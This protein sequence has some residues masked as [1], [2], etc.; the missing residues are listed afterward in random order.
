M[1]YAVIIDETN[2]DSFLPQDGKEMTELAD[3]WIGAV[4]DETDT[5]C[6]ILG[7]DYI[8]EEDGSPAFMI[9]VFSVS[10]QYEMK[11]VGDVLFRDLF[12][13]AFALHCF[14]VFA[15]EFIGEGEDE[16]KTF[17]LEN[18]F[19]E[20]DKKMPLYELSISDIKVRRPESELGCLLLSDLSEQQ[21]EVFAEE[22]EDYSFPL[23]DRSRYDRNL[24]V[25]LVDD[26][27]VIQGGMLFSMRDDTVFVEGLAP[28]GSDEELL[29]NDLVFWGSEGVKKRFGADA[30]I[31]LYLPGDGRYRTM[32]LNL[33]GHKAVK[34]G[35]LVNFTFE[36]P[37]SG[38]IV[39]EDPE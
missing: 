21:W 38:G 19:F 14:A 32:L 10:E 4:D 5:A 22:T 36:V 2:R 29:I 17:L 1:Y 39:Y 28:Y 3:L 9:R 13:N 16:L 18:G 8:T 7:A 25:F 24:S 30:R 11:S 35:E 33:T 26:D 37:V 31:K 20:E 23:M 27:A 6:G 12:D 34:L 15:T